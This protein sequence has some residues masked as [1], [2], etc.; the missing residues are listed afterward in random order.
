MLVQQSLQWI[1]T[2]R[3]VYSRSVSRRIGSGSCQRTAVS[4]DRC[5]PALTGM[6]CLLIPTERSHQLAKADRYCE[7]NW[8]SLKMTI[9]IHWLTR[10]CYLSVPRNFVV[11]GYAQFPETLLFVVW[12]FFPRNGKFFQDPEKLSPINISSAS[13]WCQWWTMKDASTIFS[14]NQNWSNMLCTKATNVL[15]K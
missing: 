14:K 3:G 9:G 5:S 2:L 6:R 12:K 7:G 10:C 1:A 8:D 11:M 4:S 13:W 15:K